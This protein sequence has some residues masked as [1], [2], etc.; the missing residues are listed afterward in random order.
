MIIKHISLEFIKDLVQTS[1]GVTN[2]EEKK[3]NDHK[4]WLR[5]VCFKL[6]KD[7]L[8]KKQAPLRSIG[9]LYN[10]DHATVLN[11]IKQ[12]DSLFNQRD[13]EYCKNVYSYCYTVL[14]NIKE[15]GSTNSKKSI[16]KT[17]FEIEGY[18]RLRHISYSLRIRKMFD[19]MSR[20]IENLSKR[21]VFAQI[22][23]LSDEDLADFEVRA[24][25][26][27][28]MKRVKNK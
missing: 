9:D 1:S 17:P 12:F 5:F 16:K 26:F 4:A 22:A 3:R 19:S 23:A 21:D 11:G 28:Q 27:L 25:A 10:K 24:N 20:K 8:T 13:F 14:N 6:S 18:Y 2:L 7:F 15:K